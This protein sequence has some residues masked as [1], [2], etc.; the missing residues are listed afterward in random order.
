MWKP[1]SAGKNPDDYIASAPSK[2]DRGKFEDNVRKYIGRLLAER[3]LPGDFQVL[4][5]ISDE[6]R[7]TDA[8]IRLMSARKVEADWKSREKVMIETENR[9]ADLQQYLE[10]HIPNNISDAQLSVTALV[11][12]SILA[13]LSN[14]QNGL[15][16]EFEQIRLHRRISESMMR[17]L[18]LKTSR[19]SYVARLNSFVGDVAVRLN[20]KQNDADK[21]VAGVMSAAGAFSEKEKA[22]DVLERIPMARSRAQAHIRKEILDKGEFPVFQAKP[23]G[24]NSV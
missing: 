12:D 14:L 13:K 5:E 7:R 4:F 9:M 10:R 21:I 20:L 17:A 16:R 22:N 19:H 11:A 24:K 23:K 8:A 1:K 3:L 2:L 6:Y 18:N 15:K